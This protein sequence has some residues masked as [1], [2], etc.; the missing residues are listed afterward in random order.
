MPKS[1]GKISTQIGG[2]IL[3]AI[4]VVV[5]PQVNRSRAGKTG[6]E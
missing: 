6:V 3:A 4:L 1:V 2:R 5:Q